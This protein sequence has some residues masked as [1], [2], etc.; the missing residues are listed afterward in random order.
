MAYRRRGLRRRKSASSGKWFKSYM[1]GIVF[2]VLA[3][4]TIGAVTYL[5]NVIPDN[6]IWV[7]G[8]RVGVGTTV[9]TG[10]SGVSSKLIVGVLGWA[11]GIIVFISAINRLKVR[12]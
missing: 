9:P 3:V 10:A 4:F 2:L 6:Y 12:I 8:T 11:V 1:L 5:T 7:N